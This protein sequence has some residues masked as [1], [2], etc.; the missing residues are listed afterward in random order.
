MVDSLLSTTSQPARD[1][2]SPLVIQTSI[3][4]SSAANQACQILP[5][6]FSVV[7]QAVKKNNL[8]KKKKAVTIMLF[9]A[10]CVSGFVK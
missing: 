3:P 7:T 5:K 9:K 6:V 4:D 1:S 8:Q 10:D 2:Q